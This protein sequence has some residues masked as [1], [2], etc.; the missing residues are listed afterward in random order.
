MTLLLRIWR[1]DQ[2]E[3]GWFP[4]SEK[5]ANEKVRP[6]CGGGRHQMEMVK[7]WSP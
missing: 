4:V 3:D 1:L 2:S 7:P 5:V 6:C